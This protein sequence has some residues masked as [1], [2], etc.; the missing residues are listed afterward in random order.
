MLF[1]VVLVWSPVAFAA[2]L[3]GT[4]LVDLEASDSV[5]GLLEA[6]GVGYLQRK[7][8]AKAEVTLRIVQ[9]G[10]EVAVT[11]VT[12]FNSR[13]ST[14]VIDGET[15]AVDGDGKQGEARHVWEDDVLVSTVTM[16]D[17]AVLTVYLSVD[18][19]GTTLTQRVE[20]R[21]PDG[22]THLANRVFRRQGP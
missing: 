10:D 18:E 6:Q 5:D 1:G 2:E 7:A 19:G 20:Y 11:T 4:W 16:D 15:R 12:P 22:A 8:A 3:T 21:T 9:D 17:G 14:L 13:T